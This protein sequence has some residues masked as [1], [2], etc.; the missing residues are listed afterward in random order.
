MPLKRN[1][2]AIPG[3]S[4]KSENVTVAE[5]EVVKRVA[6]NGTKQVKVGKHISGLHSIVRTLPSTMGDTE[7]WLGKKV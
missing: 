7:A 4:R 1:L 3:Y 6:G 2:S 5:V